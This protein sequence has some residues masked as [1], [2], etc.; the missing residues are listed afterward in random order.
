G[1]E[2]LTPRR[3]RTLGYGFGSSASFDGLHYLL[4]EAFVGTEPSGTLSDTFLHGV[5]AAVGYA[6][7]P[8]FALMH[9]A[10]YCQRTASNWAAHRVLDEFPEFEDERLFVG[11][12]IY[13][14]FFDEDPALR[15]LKECAELLA[16]YEDWPALYDT[17]R[18][19]ANTVPAFAAVYYDDMYVDREHSMRTAASITGLRAWVT[20]E[21][22]HNGLSA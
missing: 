2:R 14:W 4:E 7:R 12:M 18:L 17:G 15:P 16:A 6:T 13:P 19:A 9:E 10:I 8:L 21:Y 1:G 11:E 5:N 20:S 3:F 22:A